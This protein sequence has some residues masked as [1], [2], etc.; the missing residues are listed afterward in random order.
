MDKPPSAG[1]QG[2]PANGIQVL[3]KINNEM[4]VS[5]LISVE[6]IGATAPLHGGE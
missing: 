3:R 5:F 2:P 4:Y 6:A 1:L